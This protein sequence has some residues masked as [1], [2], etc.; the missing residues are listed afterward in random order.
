MFIKGLKSFQDNAKLPGSQC[1]NLISKADCQFTI[2]FY[3]H[4][5]E[6]KLKRVF[7]DFDSKMSTWHREVHSCF[8]GC[9]KIQLCKIPLQ[10]VCFEISE[11][12]VNVKTCTSMG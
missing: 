9:I 8:E 4:V 6:L 1:D 3:R 2:C 10:P 5:A 11:Q 7:G 12:K